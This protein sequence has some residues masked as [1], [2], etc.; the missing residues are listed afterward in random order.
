[1]KAF[2]GLGHTQRADYIERGIYPQPFKLSDG[3]RAKAWF[4]SEVA[5]FQRWRKAR[6][7]GTAAEGST[8]RDFLD[9]DQTDAAS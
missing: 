4:G 2:D 1:M 9:G 7:D 6:R 8:W 5:A 3:G